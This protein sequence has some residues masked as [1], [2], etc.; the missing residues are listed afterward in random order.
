M[1]RGRRYAAFTPSHAVHQVLPSP[2]DGVNVVYTKDPVEVEAWLRNNVIDNEGVEALGMDIEWK[3]HGGV[4]N[5]TAVLQ[6]ATAN[7]VLVAHIHHMST[8]PKLLKDVLKNPDIKKVGSGISEDMA[9]LKRDTGMCC[10]GREDTQIL[11][12]KLGI[13][14]AEGVGLKKLALRFL[15]VELNKPKRVSTS[16]WEAFT[17][18]SSQIEYAAMDAWIG[19]KLYSCM[20]EKLASRPLLIG[21][22][23]L[24]ALFGLAIIFLTFYY[25]VFSTNY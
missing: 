8:I 3:P 6:L 22:L 1:F 17:L 24:L 4:E 9:K 18:S 19:L 20:N 23:A 15:G 25:F 16:N 11:A 13:G 12:V 2:A 10:A 21:V 14:R 7:S 5:K